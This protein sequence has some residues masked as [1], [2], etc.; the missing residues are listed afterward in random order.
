M[1]FLTALEF[2]FMGDPTT[3]LIPDWSPDLNEKILADISLCGNA[4]LITSAQFSTQPRRLL[5]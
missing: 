1:F 2:L 4:F 3:R 5:H